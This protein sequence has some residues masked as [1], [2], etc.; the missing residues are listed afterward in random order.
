MKKLYAL[1]VVA[2]FLLVVQAGATVIIGQVGS[3]LPMPTVNYFGAG[4]QTFGNYTWSSTNASTQGGSVYGYTG[5]YGYLANGSWDG[6]LGPM[7]GV[8]DSFGVYGV[9]DTMT[10]AFATPVSW[11]GGFFNYVPGG[12]T[13]TTLAV[14][15]TSSVLIESYNL[16]FLTG[17]GLNSGEWIRFVESTPIGSFTMSDNYVGVTGQSV[18]P[19]PEPG[20]IALLGSGIVGLAGFAR[21]KFGV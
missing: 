9:T 19:T 6:A 1:L 8:N 17:G 2:V 7:A 13:P 3:N 18:T 12:S 5:G 15:D 10:F 20:T 21:R 11:V 14:Y 4:P 16:T